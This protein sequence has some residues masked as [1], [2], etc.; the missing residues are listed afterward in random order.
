MAVRISCYDFRQDARLFA[1]ARMK[2]EILAGT[3]RYRRANLVQH[4]A[5]RLCA[6]GEHFDELWREL[7]L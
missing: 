5:L 6:F 7:G 1:S 3:G 4:T 2:G